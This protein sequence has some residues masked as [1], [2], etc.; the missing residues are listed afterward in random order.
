MFFSF[1]E[2]ET[3]IESL[4]SSYGRKAADMWFGSSQSLCLKKCLPNSFPSK[5]K[6][7]FSLN[8]FFSFV[9]YVIMKWKHKWKNT[10]SSGTSVQ[11]VHWTQ[12]GFLGQRPVVHSL[13]FDNGTIH[14]DNTITILILKIFSNLK[15]SMFLWFCDSAHLRGPQQFL[16]CCK[17]RCILSVSTIRRNPSFRILK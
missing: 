17:L 16:P 8:K 3:I 10:V 5:A 7:C 13:L 9:S 11:Q 6:G 1:F 14:E 4:A 15:D 2:R 12:Q